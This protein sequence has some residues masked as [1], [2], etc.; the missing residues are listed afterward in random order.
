MGKSDKKCGVLIVLTVF[1][2]FLAGLFGLF[3]EMPRLYKTEMSLDFHKSELSSNEFEKISLEK[4][5]IKEVASKRTPAKVVYASSNY[6][7]SVNQG[8][9]NHISVAGRNL[10]V[11]EVSSLVVN[12]GNA[13]MKF[14]KMIYGHNSAGIFG[15]LQSLGVGSVFSVELN[16]VTTN[17]RVSEKVTFEK[18]S[19]TTLRVNGQTYTMDALTRNAKGHGLMLL[20]CAGQGLV[21]GDAT[22]RLAVFADAI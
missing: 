12:P 5:E 22:H 17:Y 6:S 15:N 2:L 16:G 4:T 11:T 10:G 1:G 19:S 21:G 20:T 9:W 3:F 14:R 13:T 8:N 7:T 18:A